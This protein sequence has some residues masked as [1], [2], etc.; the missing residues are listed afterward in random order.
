[1]HN[2]YTPQLKIFLELLLQFVII[3][4]LDVLLQ[5]EIITI[6]NYYNFTLLCKNFTI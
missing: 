6:G 5:F 2:K 1:M 4:I 3:T